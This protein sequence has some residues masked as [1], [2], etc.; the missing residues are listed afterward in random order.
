MNTNSENKIGVIERTDED[1][2]TMKLYDIKEEECLNSENQKESSFLQLPSQTPSLDQFPELSSSFMQINTDEL[3]S[4][5][6]LA[7]KD[8]DKSELDDQVKCNANSGYS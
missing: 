3:L 1:E 7:L 4:S 2:Y 5:L 8:M 6:G